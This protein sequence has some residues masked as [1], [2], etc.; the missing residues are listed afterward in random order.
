MHSVHDVSLVAVEDCDWRL[1]LF[2]RNT[3]NNQ[4]RLNGQ[5]KTD[6]QRSQWWF[7][8]IFPAHQCYCA[9]WSASRKVRWTTSLRMLQP[10]TRRQPPQ[11]C[12][13]VVRERIITSLMFNLITPM[14][15]L[16]CWLKCCLISLKV[17]TIAIGICK[18]FFKSDRASSD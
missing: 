4:K 12:R 2:P 5:N 13:L 10:P 6:K 11:G 8:D 17:R 15:S 7:L 16:R 18:F 9:I 3:I 1:R 14:V